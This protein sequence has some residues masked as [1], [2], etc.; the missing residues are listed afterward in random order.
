MNIGSESG[1]I[2]LVEM[3]IILTIIA[4]IATIAIPGY[5]RAQKQQE[6]T[7]IIRNA[8]ILEKAVSTWA[9]ENNVAA[10]TPID[11]SAIT[12]VNVEGIQQL[13]ETAPLGQYYDIGKVGVG[14]IKIRDDVKKMY[15]KVVVGWAHF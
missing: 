12:H 1:S 3:I 14:Q 13:A 11:L 6:A 10:G 5:I 15:S 9:K 2:T 4:L 8:Y 7:K